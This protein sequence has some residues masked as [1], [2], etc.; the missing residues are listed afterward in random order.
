LVFE[1]P[2]VKLMKMPVEPLV[3]TPA[4]A[5]STPM[6][7]PWTVVS[8]D[9]TKIPWS[10]PAMTLAAFGSVPP[11][12]MVPPEPLA[13]T[14]TPPSPPMRPAMRRVPPL[15]VPTRFPWKKP[16]ALPSMRTMSAPAPAIRL[17]CAGATPPICMS[18][19]LT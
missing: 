18:G 12:K 8:F 1:T 11:M 9:S 6:K 19:A 3:M 17:R 4:C 7:L 14:F 15:S 2:L 10:T 16:A 13:K 5:A